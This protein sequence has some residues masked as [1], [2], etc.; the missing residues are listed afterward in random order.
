M[1]WPELVHWLQS[2]PHFVAPDGQLRKTLDRLVELALG[3]H[4][5]GE[6]QTEVKKA[7]ARS[8]GQPPLDPRLF[9]FL[10][11]IETRPPGLRDMQ[12]ARLF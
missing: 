5:V 11:E 10:H 3:A 7:W 12:E 1:T 4:S 2:T 6:W 9:T 8:S